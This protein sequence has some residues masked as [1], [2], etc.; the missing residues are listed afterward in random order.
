MKADETKLE[1]MTLEDLDLFSESDLEE[2]RSYRIITLGGLLNATNGL[3]LNEI[4]QKFDQSEEKLAALY[5]L[6][7]LELLENY[8]NPTINRPRG[9]IEIRDEGD[10]DEEQ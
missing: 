6:I 9:L 7:P 10:G 4:F 8:R 2:L 3:L 5:E 1:D